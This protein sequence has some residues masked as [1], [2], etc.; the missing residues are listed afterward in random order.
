MLCRFIELKASPKAS[1]T[2]IKNIKIWLSNNNN[3]IDPRETE[4]I[5]AADLISVVQ[6]PKSTFRRLV[7]QHVLVPTKGLFGLLRQS[8]S[9]ELGPEN[10]RTIV[11][12]S[13]EHVD[14]LAAVIVFI[15]AVVMLI[16]PLWVLAIVQDM[17]RKLA[18]IT[19]FLTVFLAVLTWGT[20]S[21]P[22][23]ILA[24]TAG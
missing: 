4:F 9:Q 15:V 1:R 14:I 17:F 5:R 16:V 7:E 20:F 24:A 2:T 23:E 8:Q 10:C 19:V 11:Q 6:S 18:V 21:R 13:D 22:F 12:G 3:P